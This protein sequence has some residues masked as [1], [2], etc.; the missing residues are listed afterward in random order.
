M[1]TGPLPAYPGAQDCHQ[2][3]SNQQ[4]GLFRILSER[5]AVIGKNCLKTRYS[6]NYGFPSTR[7]AGKIMRH[8]SAG[9]G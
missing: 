1:P 8:Y 6:W 2:L 7:E 3:G 9:R 5:Q 4:P